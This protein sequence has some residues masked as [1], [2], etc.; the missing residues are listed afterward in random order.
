MALVDDI[1]DL[2]AMRP[3]LT[4]AQISEHLYGRSGY[5]QKVNPTCRRLLKLGRVR[6]EGNG[7]QSDPYTYHRNA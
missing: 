5:Q 7:Y 2:I 4:E 3:G 1:E 6:R